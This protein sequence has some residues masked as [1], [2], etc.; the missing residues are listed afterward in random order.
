MPQPI[1]TKVKVPVIECVSEAYAFLAAYWLK[2]LPAAC[3]VAAISTISAML[4]SSAFLQLGFA[5]ISGLA[6]VAYIAAI[7]RQQLYD[8]YTAPIGL[9]LG[10][11]EFRLFAVTL[12]LAL[13]LVPVAFLLFMFGM[14][15]LI[16]RME[17]SEA[18]LEALTEQPEALRDAVLGAATPSDI[19]LAIILLAPL[20]WLAARLFIINAATIGESKLAFAEAWRWSSGNAWRIAAA[21]TLTAAP[22]LL[23]NGIILT[24]GPG[25]LN[26][27]PQLAVIGV[28]AT[29][30][31]S[32]ILRIPLIVLSAILYQGLRVHPSGDREI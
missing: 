13:I 2:F 25:M 14:A 15:V 31:V 26:P 28:A 20:L 18:E 16:A 6:G 3:A 19:L 9:G 29:G 11:D 7:L 5:L 12:L 10:V 27:S 30:I 21:M 24:I 32:G 23:F 17:V 22:L 4:S 8:Q 1:N